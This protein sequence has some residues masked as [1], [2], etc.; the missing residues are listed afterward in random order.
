MDAADRVYRR[1][2]CRSIL[3]RHAAGE[4]DKMPGTEVV[5]VSYEGGIKVDKDPVFLYYEEEEGPDQV[6]WVV[7]SAPAGA[8][9]AV[10]RQTDGTAL[11]VIA[12]GMPEGGKAVVWGLQN[13]RLELEAKYEVRFLSNRG[14]T[15]A[16]LDP[17]IKNR[18]R[19][20]AG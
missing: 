5:T 20:I 4:D 16:E 11:E 14:E 10:I 6:K 13:S 17:K 9:A 8:V 1:D 18:P 3:E 12:P 2:G 19:K 7:E 15:L